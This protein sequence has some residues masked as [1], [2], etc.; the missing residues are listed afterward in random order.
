MKRIIIYNWIPFD[1]KENKGGGVTVYTRNLI[2]YLIR[3]GMWEVCFL[4]SGRAYNYKRRDVYIEPT[5]NL[6]GQECKSFQVVNS[7]VLSSARLSFPY[8]QDYLKDEKLLRVLRDF[9]NQIG[10]ADV[11]HFQNFEGLSLQVMKL[12]E[13]F[14]TM[15][16]IYSLHNY[17]LF[18]PQV[19]LWRGD[20]ENCPMGKCGSG[21]LECMPR[22]VY[23]KKVI[24]NQNYNYWL[25]KGIPAWKQELWKKG[26]AIIEMAANVYFSHHAMGRK[27]KRGLGLYFTAFEEKNIEY[28]NRYMDQVIAVSR[29]VG[30]IAVARGIKEHKICVG[31]IGSAVA[32]GQRNESAWEYNG[33]ILNIGYLGYMRKMKG[34][35]FLLEALE[36]MDT[37]M[38]KR[39][40]VLF[41]APLTD[42]NAYDRILNLRKKMAEVRYFDGYTHEQLPEILQGV[43]LGIV[44]ALWEDN[45]PQVA[46]EMKAHGVPVLSSHLGGAR[47]LTDSAKFVY[48]AGNR[49]DFYS[50][51]KQFLD[52]PGLLKDYW[53]S[54][55]RLLTM[56]EHFKELEAIYED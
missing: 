24:F 6:Y 36:Q 29:R 31:Y 42:Q 5:E 35:N 16:M 23:K 28:V 18:C 19:M 26:K 20:R 8:P 2:S 39:I 37:D 53:K 3:Q 54:S 45:L 11:F 56:G 30:E 12:K 55:R 49:E 32:E 41:A 14:P 17:Y 52:C 15:K 21:C 40:G 44:P 34:F 33:G 27:Q 22:D 4:S 38:A 43:H 47:E 10:G 51:L 13:Y 46:I 7:P 48:Q 25:D 50:S 9:L 1:E